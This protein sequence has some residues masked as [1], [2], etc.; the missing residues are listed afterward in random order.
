MDEKADHSLPRLG[1]LVRNVPAVCYLF[2][3]SLLLGAAAFYYTE[4]KF[5]RVQVESQEA[6]TVQLISKRLEGDLESVVA[7]LL[8][9]AGNSPLLD[10]LEKPDAPRQ[11]K[12]DQLFLKW[13]R[14]KPD[15][16]QIHFLDRE[17][18]EVIRVD[19]TQGAP[20]L[21]GKDQLADFSREYYFVNS[22]GLN[23]GEV[24]ASA[25]DLTQQGGRIVRPIHP[26]VRYCTPVF[27]RAGTRRGL[28]EFDYEGP[29]LIEHLIAESSASS[30]NIALLNSDGYW[31]KGPRPE[32]EWGFTDDRTKDRSFRHDFPEEWSKISSA[33]A[34]QFYSARGFYEIG[35]AHV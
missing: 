24:Y 7:D 13:G 27:D 14:L 30:G 10:F 23:R 6:V 21:L 33:E 4:M 3:V 20:H 2:L 11:E 29:R 19:S 5:W 9:F 25:F 34:G 16:F 35:R 31:L 26:T 32:D 15:Y 8:I 1:E 17:G 18:R 22:I 28:V 12:L